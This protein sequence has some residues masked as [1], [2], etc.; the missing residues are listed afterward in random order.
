MLDPTGIPGTRFPRRRSSARQDEPVRYSGSS[1][2]SGGDPGWA[3]FWRV[4]EASPRPQASSV[5]RGMS[6]SAIISPV[7]VRPYVSAPHRPQPRKQVPQSRSWEDLASEELWEEALVAYLRQNWRG[8]HRM[9]CVLNM[10]VAEATPECRW[11][12]R[13]F[14]REALK[15]LTRLVRQGRVLRHQ[16]KWLATLEPP[17]EVV[18]LEQVPL[19]GLRKP[20][21]PDSPQRRSHP[22]PGVLACEPEVLARVAEMTGAALVTRSHF[23]STDL[24]AHPSR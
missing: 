12:T 19:T 23:F 3:R 15:A 21:A 18:P 17:H 16:K 22:L 14:T 20:T 7:W 9:W 2:R 8:R 24:S 10:V 4:S 13:D 1:G 11:Q 6:I 5:V